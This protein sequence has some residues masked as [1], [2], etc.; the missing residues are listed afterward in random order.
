M[1]TLV[2]SHLLSVSF[3]FHLSPSVLSKPPALYSSSSRSLLSHRPPYGG[4]RPGGVRGGPGGGPGGVPG[5]VPGGAGG[6]GPGG[7]RGGPGG[8]GGGPGGSGGV[9]GGR[10]GGWGGGSTVRWRQVKLSG[11]GVILL[12]R[13]R[14][15]SSFI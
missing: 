3:F 1:F 7:V 5:G 2:L 15:H 13:G 9:R 4:A 8:S 6:G 12:K 11:E 14:L 10:E